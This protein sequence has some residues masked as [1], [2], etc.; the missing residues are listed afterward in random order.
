MFEE[1]RLAFEL[2]VGFC[3]KLAA[4]KPLGCCLRSRR[5]NLRGQ[6]WQYFTSIFC[7]GARMQQMRNCVEF[8]FNAVNVHL[9]RYKDKDISIF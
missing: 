4:R 9:T 8:R 3:A 1:R 7:G 6:R 2:E 5:S